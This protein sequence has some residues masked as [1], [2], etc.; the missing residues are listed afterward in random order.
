[1]PEFT[2]H[3]GDADLIVRILVRSL[4]SHHSLENKKIREQLVS[5]GSLSVP[6]LIQALSSPSERLR[7]EAAKALGEI[8][9][10]RAAQALVKLLKDKNVGVRWTAMDSLITLDQA[11]IQPV[12]LAL[13]K[14]F[15]S[16]WLREGAHH[17][18][19]VLKDKG[20]LPHPVEQV[21]TALESI[22]PEV[23]VPW[24]VDCAL[25]EMRLLD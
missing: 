5:L 20:R 22:E 15:E 19:H 4:D 17:V 7:W 16:P 6:S 9:D 13:E 23:Q 2:H 21:F 1:M 24:A 8:G 11:A 18:L 12:L 25:H 3:Q 14:D 10:P